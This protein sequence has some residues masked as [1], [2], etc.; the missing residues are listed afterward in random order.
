MEFL[1]KEETMEEKKLNE[2]MYGETR[3]QKNEGKK[4]M[5]DSDDIYTNAYLEAPKDETHVFI[6]KAEKLLTQT[7]VNELVGKARREGRE[8]AMKE[9]LERYGVNSNEEFDNLLGKGQIYDYFNQEYL[10]K[11]KSYGDIRA[12][13]ALLKTHIDPSRFEDVKLILSGKGLEVNEE[14][15]EKFKES[16]PEWIVDSA[17]AAA[18]N[19]DSNNSEKEEGESAKEFSVEDG[20]KLL[21]NSML[22]K[23]KPQKEAATLRKLGN[24][25]TPK[26]AEDEGWDKVRKMFGL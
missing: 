25:A 17:T 4:E 23:T 22:E 8:S 18:P 21:E 20:K 12:E 16:H 15:I 1:E 11:E 26:E 24:E 9:L 10:D 13:N 7:Q 6:P 19:L 14:N 5:P 3:S 2:E